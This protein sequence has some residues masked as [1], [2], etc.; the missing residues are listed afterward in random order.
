MAE[1][2]EVLRNLLKNQKVTP[3]LKLFLTLGGLPVWFVKTLQFIVG[4]KD[5]FSASTIG[6]TTGFKS[7]ADYFQHITK[8]TIWQEDFMKVWVDEKL[9][10]V[11]CPVY[12]SPAVSRDKA[13]QVTPCGIY[14]QMYNALNYPAGVIPV[15]KVTQD[16]VNKTFDPKFFTPKCYM[17]KILQK[18][19]KDSVGLSV[20][21]QCVALPYQEE[22]C[23]RVMRDV[24]KCLQGKK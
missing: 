2:G 24:N 7:L 18:S 22:I 6:G 4:L 21:V 14:C 9:D 11:I 20:G 17:E 1:R 15:T 3:S 8:L 10:A 13:H 23:L 16:D 12:P 5:Q 19:S